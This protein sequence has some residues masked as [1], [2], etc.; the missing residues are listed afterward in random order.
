MRKLQGRDRENNGSLIVNELT[1]AERRWIIYIQRKHFGEVLSAIQNSQCRIC[2]RY[3]GGPYKLPVMPPHPK[4][5]VPETP[6]FTHTGLDYF[7][8]LYVKSADGKTKVLVCLFTCMVTRAI[9]LEHVQNMSSEEFLLGF[10]RFVS[11]RGV[12]NE[13]ISDNALQFKTASRTLDILWSN[14]VTRAELFFGAKNQLEFHSRIGTLDGWI[15]REISGWNRLVNLWLKGQNAFW[16]IWQEEYLLGLRERAQVKLK[17]KKIVSV[18]ESSV[19]D[20]VIIKDELPRSSW[21]MGR[22]EETQQS[23]DGKVRSA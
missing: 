18:M 8:P 16:R 17:S 15:L 10:R 19:G 6:P 23:K 12:P 11:Q 7:G 21:R 9:H 13:I 3:E 4:S 14:I 5:R 20:I 1:E 2:R 22:I